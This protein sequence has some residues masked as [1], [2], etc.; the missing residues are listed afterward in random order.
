MAD[1]LKAFME[2]HWMFSADIIGHSM[3][4]KVA[5]Q[6]ALSHPEM[7]NKLIVV[8]IEPFQAD[9]DHAEHYRGESGYGSGQNAD[10][11]RR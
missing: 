5:M 6:L 8:D 9:D 4:G 11:T 3:G 2:A 10:A 7:V 1:D